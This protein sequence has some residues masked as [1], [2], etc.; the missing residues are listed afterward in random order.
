MKNKTFLSALPPYLAFLSVLFDFLT[1]PF[2]VC[3]TAFCLTVNYRDCE[4]CGTRDMCWVSSRLRGTL[5]CNCYSD[6]YEYGDCCTD[7]YYVDNCLGIYVEFTLRYYT[8]NMNS[9]TVPECETGT[10]RLVGGTTNS[11]GRLEICANGVWGRVC[12]KLQYWGPD[13]A[14]VVCRQLGFS[15][16][17]KLYTT[18]LLNQ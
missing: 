8:Y 11:T 18:V 16:K 10:V 7:V 4:V 15:D 1:L 12:N 6:C 2:T 14:M 13:N 9:N 17:G 3:F 5:I